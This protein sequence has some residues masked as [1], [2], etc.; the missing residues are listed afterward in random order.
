MAKLELALLV[1]ADS[2]KW[3]ADFNAALD[4][5]EKLLPKFEQAEKEMVEEDEGE[6]EEE[7]PKKAKKA[8]KQPALTPDDDDEEEDDLESEDEEKDDDSDGD[9]ESDG[10]D[11]EEP[12]PKKSAKKGKVKEPTND[13][14]QDAAKAL[15]RAIGGSAGRKKVF[16]ILKKKPFAVESVTELKPKHYAAF[17]AVTKEA[18]EEA[19]EE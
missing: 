6:E 8:K 12:A 1:G 7:T 5:A 4:R 19:E 14:C 9:D 2:K 11:D 15:A 17:I 13:D 3:L 10:D 18:L 16:A